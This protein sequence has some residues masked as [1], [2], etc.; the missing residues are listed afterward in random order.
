MNNHNNK[1]SWENIKHKAHDIS[2]STTLSNAIAILSLLVAIYFGHMAHTTVQQVDDIQETVDKLSIIS[3][4]QSAQNAQTINNNGSS[5]DD[6]KNISNEEFSD[7]MDRLY[8][9]FD[10]IEKVADNPHLHFSIIWSG[11]Q[12]ELDNSDKSKLPDHVTYYI[13]DK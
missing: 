13:S 12:E 4:S 2:Q 9:T 3:Y 11:T 1:F 10:I 8:E 5:Y 7:R 6:I